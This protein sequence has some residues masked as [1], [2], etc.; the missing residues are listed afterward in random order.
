MHLD[1][2]VLTDLLFGCQDFD[3]SNNNGLK[4]KNIKLSKIKQTI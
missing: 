2:Q 4:L 1:D 3:E